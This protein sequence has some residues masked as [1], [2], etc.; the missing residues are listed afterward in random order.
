M[1]L[2]ALGALLSHWRRR[3]FQLAM[4]ML[5]LSLATAL[6]SGVQ[7]I[8][9]EARASY[10]RAASMLGQDRLEQLVSADGAPFSQQTF[11]A[12]RRAGWL[13]SPVLE[14]DLRIGG[15]RLHVIGIDPLS[16][17]DE[18]HQ[19]DLGGTGNLRDFATP[20]GQLIV[21]T[22]TADRLRSL[23][24]PPLRVAGQMLP[25]TAIT[26]IGIAQ[27]LL[28]KPDQL[29]KLIVARDQPEGLPPI[30][31]IAPE[32]V[33]KQPDAQGD[34][35]RLTDSF[36]LN[37][38]AFGFLAFAVGLFIVYSAI[39]L[40]FEQ[41]R[42]T[43]RTLRSLGVSATALTLLLLGELLVLST[44]AGLAGVALG[45]VVAAV[46]LP[47]VAATLQGLYGAAVPGTLSFRPEWWA[48]G[49]GIAIAGALLSSA[50]SLWRVWRMPLLAPAQPRAWARASEAG[51]RWQAV[52]ALALLILSAALAHWG[53]GLPAGFGVLGGLLLGAALLLPVLLGL[54]L[55]AL[56]RASKQALTVWF[57]A[58]TRQQLPGLSLALMAL[59]LALSANIGVGT[60]V[61]SFRATFVGWLDQR[62]AAELYVTA[63]S[64]DEA[65]RLRMWLPQHVDAILP[66]WNVDGEVLGQ[67]VQIYGVADDRTYRDHWPLLDGTPDVWDRVAQGSGV[68]INEQL[69]RRE[70]L[71]IGD[72]ISLGAGWKTEIAGVYSDYG[73]PM[74]QVIVGIDQL[75][76]HH[77]D[78]PRLRYGLRIAPDGVEQVRD[79]LVSEFGLPPGNVVDQAS[80]KRASVAIFERTFSVTAAL[81]ILTLM[82]AGLAMFASLLT[83]SGIRLPQLAP[84][85]ALGV[86]R[87]KLVLLELARTMALCVMTLL[88]ALPVGLG[89]AWVLL[90]IVNVE[91][92]G[93]RLPM[94][95]FPTDWLRLGVIASA[96]AL[97]SVLIPLSRLAKV[98]P[99][100]LLKV[101][102]NER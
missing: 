1:F 72:T 52:L 66:I 16:I 65:A 84:V 78:V 22:E 74:G 94:R 63:R 69:W 99:S 27:T 48:A 88:A 36:H 13:V 86:T 61:S 55:F 47:G 76:S 82:V 20:P 71:S 14:G 28:G 60:M 92:F 38:T 3:P 68:L 29:S 97:L 53:R 57:W 35:G 85:W 102:A 43:F 11:V 2:T 79:R 42:S 100:D 32:L 46:L 101:F 93:W 41:R 7:A 81:N 80:L 15:V 40:A 17:P 75:V 89:L 73:N 98:A 10:A 77:P 4:L 37:L 33:L 62:L 70:R 50:Q 64:E 83:L 87:R 19:V 18:A 12:L 54:I 58:D 45:Y 49:L 31:Q 30:D 95:V 59:L 26:D 51:L 39:G 91:A 25:N 8:N 21:S 24:L 5:G 56:Q 96:A 44:A 90:A 6:W 23:P 34:I 9:A 67:R